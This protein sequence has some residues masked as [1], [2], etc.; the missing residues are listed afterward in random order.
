MVFSASFNNISVISQ[1]SVLLVDETGVKRKKKQQNK[2]NTILCKKK[3]KKTPIHNHDPYFPH[4]RKLNSLN[5]NICLIPTNVKAYNNMEM[6]NFVH[7][8]LKI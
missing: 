1:R 6:F 2:N 3:D 8:R 7:E 5:T 4:F